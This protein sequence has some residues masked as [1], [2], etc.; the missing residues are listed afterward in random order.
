[1][2]E[3]AAAAA[4]V[5]FAAVG[6]PDCF[7]D[8]SSEPRSRGCSPTTAAAPPSSQDRLVLREGPVR[9][10]RLRLGRCLR[11]DQ[12]SGCTT[13]EIFYE[14]SLL[15]PLPSKPK[16]LALVTRRFRLSSDL[17][18]SHDSAISFK[19]QNASTNSTC[20]REVSFLWCSG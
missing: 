17:A 11:P 5:A 20:L 14:L 4:D 18:S 10:P 6:G 9:C 16:K 2:A 12:L 1:M 13:Y 3:V 7:Q 15:P 19:F 8:K